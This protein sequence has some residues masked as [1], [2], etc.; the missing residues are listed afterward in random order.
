MAGRAA[1]RRSARCASG[2]IVAPHGSIC[3]GLSVPSKSETTSHGVAPEG[4]PGELERAVGGQPA[5]LDA[6]AHGAK[7][8]TPGRIDL[9]PVAKPGMVPSPKST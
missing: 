1:S 5:P 2:T 8:A 3:S 7:V 6:V 9:S 4:V